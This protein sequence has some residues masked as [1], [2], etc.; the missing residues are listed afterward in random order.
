[1]ETTYLV[2]VF[3]AALVATVKA[4]QYYSKASSLSGDVDRL[5]SNLK[6]ADKATLEKSE[7]VFKLTALTAKLAAAVEQYRA[8]C[9]DKD[10]IALELETANSKLSALTKDAAKP[11]A[12]VVE[13]VE[14][15]QPIVEAVAAVAPVSVLVEPVGNAVV[16]A[17]KKVE[18]PA[19]TNNR[20][21]NRRKR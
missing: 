21:S 19:P 5:K 2:F 9:R 11:E 16:E 18:T 20:K 6:L 15:A 3:V 17:P 12:K 7:E 10:V 4:I 1:M 8:C 14:V 13:V